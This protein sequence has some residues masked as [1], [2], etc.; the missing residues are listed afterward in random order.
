MTLEKIKIGLHNAVIRVRQFFGHE[1]ACCGYFKNPDGK[2]V[3]CDE[4]WGYQE[5]MFPGC[6][7]YQLEHSDGTPNKIVYAKDKPE[8]VGTLVVDPVGC[9]N[10]GCEDCPKF[11]TKD[12][13]HIFVQQLAIARHHATHM[14]FYDGH[15]SERDEN[16][17]HVDT[18]VSIIVQV[19]TAVA[20]HDHDALSK[21]FER[22]G[23]IRDKFPDILFNFDV[24]FEPQEV[25]T[26][27]SE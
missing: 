20:N 26:S 8:L 21:V 3:D 19:T 23:K 18:N 10:A 25:K 14:M 2:L 17:R 9:L 13:L 7:H 5:C 6:G 16:V 11:W 4:W 12:D 22:E 1:A 24:R 15:G 27:I